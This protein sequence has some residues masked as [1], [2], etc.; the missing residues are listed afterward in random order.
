MCLHF[1]KRPIVLL[2]HNSQQ[3]LCLPQLH[4]LCSNE[5]VMGLQNGVTAHPQQMEMDVEIPD[6][7]QIDVSIFCLQFSWEWQDWV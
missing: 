1:W 2:V 3:L 7:M 4:I 5:P 6:P